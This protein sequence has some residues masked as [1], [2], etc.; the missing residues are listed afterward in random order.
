LAGTFNSNAA[1]VVRNGHTIQGVAS[2]LTSTTAQASFGL[3]YS[4]NTYGWKKLEV[5]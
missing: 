5:F 3:V 2:D 1:T 4:N